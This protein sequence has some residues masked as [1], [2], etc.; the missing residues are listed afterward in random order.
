MLPRHHKFLLL[1]AAVLLFSSPAA[2]STITIPFSAANFS[3]P[4]DIDNTFYPL[5][6]GT[7]QTYVAETKDGCEVDVVTV[8]NDTRVI[9]GV[10]T[11]VVRDTAYEG[12]TCTTDPSALAEDTLDYFAQDNAGN[13][14]YFG[15]D[16][17]DCPI[18]TCPPGDGSWLAGVNGAL[19]GII[20]L[21]DPGSGD[22]Y[23][24]EVAEGVAEDWGM[25][26]NLN[27]TVHLRRDDAFPPGEF[28]GCLV[29]KEWNGLEPGSVEHKT[30]CPDV[31]LVLVEEHSG[32]LV[33]FELVTNPS[34]ALRFRTVPRP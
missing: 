20:M 4:L 24:Q 29:T 30:Y 28:D 10:T 27:A 2:A 14:W 12:E 32:A 7:T 13:V 21:A 34:D 23:R 16:T 17:F 33:R 6:P 5:V 25:V 22:R 8:T 1:A 15:E 11:R 26:M 9:A 18:F 3:D 31:G 19:P